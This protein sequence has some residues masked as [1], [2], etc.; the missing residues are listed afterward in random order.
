MTAYPST[1]KLDGATLTADVD[2]FPSLRAGANELWLTLNRDLGGA[3]NRVQ[4]QP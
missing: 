3:A 1:V 2:Y 4:L